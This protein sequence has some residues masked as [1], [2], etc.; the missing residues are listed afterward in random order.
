MALALDDSYALS[1][2]P[3]GQAELPGVLLGILV[4]GML[5]RSLNPRPKL[6]GFSFRGKTAGHSETGLLLIIA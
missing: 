6:A 1:H 5:R 2:C 4:F 3:Q